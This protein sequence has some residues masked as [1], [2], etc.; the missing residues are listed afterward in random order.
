MNLHHAQKILVLVSALFF[1][2]ILVA[3]DEFQQA[4]Q[5]ITEFFAETSEPAKDPAMGA[6]IRQK[7]ADLPRTVTPLMTAGII[8]YLDARQTSSVTDLT[9]SIARSLSAPA[10]NINTAA[11]AEG[12]ASVVKQTNPEAFIVAYNISTCAACSTSWIGIFQIMNGSWSLAEHL[13]NPMPNNAVHLAWI[14]Q[15]QEPM[16]L[17][18]GIHWGD[19]HNRLDLHLYSLKDCITEIWSRSDLVEGTIAL[20]GDRITLTSWTEFRQPCQE[21][22]EVIQFINGHAESLSTSFSEVQ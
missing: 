11:D 19:A 5:K 6:M 17:L 1:A 21:K 3:Q 15:A 7:A 18:Y 13:E 2:R 12:L 8:K 9:I 20:S 4:H 22:H 16:L 10:M 14:D